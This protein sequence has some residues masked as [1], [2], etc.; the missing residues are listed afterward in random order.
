MWIKYALYG[1]LLAVVSGCQTTP[2]YS[3]TVHTF[4]GVKFEYHIPWT[5]NDRHKGDVLKLAEISGVTNIDKVEAQQMFPG[6]SITIVVNEK[7]SIHER[8]VSQRF[9][10]VQYANWGAGFKIEPNAK[11]VGKFTLVEDWVTKKTILKAA[12]KEYRVELSDSIS[13]R[14]AEDILGRFLAMDVE[15]KSASYGPSQLHSDLGSAEI[16]AIKEDE[17][18]MFTILFS[19]QYSASEYRFLRDPK[20]GVITILA[21]GSIVV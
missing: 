12:G 16:V 4:N 5:L 3:P 18:G 15:F 19:R 20:T 6:N 8:T 17:R 11:Q 1:L 10:R 2:D 21:V 9:L 7:E 13:V 14:V